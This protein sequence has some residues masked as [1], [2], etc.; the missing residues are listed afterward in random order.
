[1]PRTI[2]SRLASAAL[3]AVAA[4]PVY[5]MSACATA[6]SGVANP[7]AGLLDPASDPPGL[8]VGDHAPEGELLDSDSNAVR[9]ADLYADQPT[10]LIFY[11]G[12][13]C[14]YCTRDLRE[15]EGALP[16]FTDAGARVV[17]VSLETPEH[18]LE[19]RDTHGLS[20]DVL[21]DPSGDVV[22]GF[23]L[24]FQLDE[25]TKTRYKG[26][27]IDLATHNANAS[28]ELPAPAVYVVDTTGVIRYANADWDYTERVGHEDALETVRGLN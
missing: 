24:G 13:W 5:V 21:V 27:G 17:A 20:Y 2:L 16:E 19:T 8:A 22:R 7:N 6:D 1:M 28:W 9:V 4:T 26:Y 14:P 10:V 11:R 3:V 15:W 23:R 12:G 18:A 25:T